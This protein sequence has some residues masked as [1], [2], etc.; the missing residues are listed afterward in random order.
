MLQEMTKDMGRQL[1]DMDAARAPERLRSADGQR[2][3]QGKKGPPRPK[4]YGPRARPCLL[5]SLASAACVC[6]SLRASPPQAGVLSALAHHCPAPGPSSRVCPRLLSSKGAPDRFLEEF[7]SFTA[8]VSKLESW[9]V[10]DAGAA[11]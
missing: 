10:R 2:P 3:A 5:A 9:Q 6:G 4:T 7:L 8:R 11:T 1:R